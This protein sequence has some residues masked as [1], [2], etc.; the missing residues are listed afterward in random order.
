MFQNQWLLLANYK[1]DSKFSAF[2]LARILTNQKKS[3][4]C[5]LMICPIIDKSYENYS[6]I[7][8]KKYI[9]IHLYCN[10]LSVLTFAS[11]FR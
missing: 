3:K 11:F 9:Y 2:L 10:L 5:T 4:I 6:L 7:G 1:L 8:R